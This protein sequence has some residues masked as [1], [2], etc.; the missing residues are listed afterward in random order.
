MQA[1]MYGNLR[2]FPHAFEAFEELKRN[3]DV[4]KHS[5]EICAA[6]GSDRSA[7]CYGLSVF[8]AYAARK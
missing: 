4:D 5:A 7:Q 3:Y 8:W 1:E 2:D 6:Y